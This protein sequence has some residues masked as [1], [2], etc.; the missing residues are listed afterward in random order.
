MTTTTTTKR[1]LALAS[2]AALMALAACGVEQTDTYQAS[3][4]ALYSDKPAAITCYAYGVLTFNGTSTGKVLYDEGGR[5]SFVDAEN[6][7][8]TTLE[9]ECRVVYAGTAVASASQP[10]GR[11]R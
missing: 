4:D 2:A 9:G 11:G 6:G 8:L 10:A 3:R 7:R 5:I 1:L